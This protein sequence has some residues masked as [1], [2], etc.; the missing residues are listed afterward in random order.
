[1]TY[2]EKVRVILAS[3][4]IIA[5]VAAPLVVYYIFKHRK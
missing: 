3:V 2:Y 4:Q 1:M 5:T